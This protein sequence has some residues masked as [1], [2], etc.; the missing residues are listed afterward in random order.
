MCGISGFID[1][2]NISGLDCIKAMTDVLHHRGPDDSGLF[3]KQYEG[4]HVGLGHR[5]LSILD[6]SSHGHQP[7]DHRHL[8]I[9]YNGEVYNFKEIRTEL[10][11]QGYV[12]DSGSDTE[13]ILKAYHCW[14]IEMVHRLNGMFALAIFDAEKKELVLLRDRAGV[15]P[16]YWYYHD[17]LFLF[18]SELKSF[19]QHPAFK[20]ELCLDGLALFLQYGYIPQPHSIFKHTQKLKAGNSL[21]INLD[22]RSFE[23]KKY[24]DV[25]DFY[26]KPK[27]K[28]S[29]EEALRETERLLTSACEY[30]MVADVPVGVFL[31]G[32]Y[33]SS[34]VTALL[35]S[36][37]SEKLKTFAIGFHEEAYNEAHHARRVAEHLGTD[38]TEYYCTHQDALDILP[39]LPEIWDEP[40]GDAST[41]PTVLVSELARKQV[42]VSLSADGGDE[43][44]GGYDKYI[45]AK[46]MESIFGR[47]P[48]RNQFGRFL[49]SIKPGSIP[50]LSRDPIFSRRYAKVASSL[51]AKHSTEMLGII[52]SAFFRAEVEELIAKPIVHLA[53]DFESYEGLDEFNDL[54]N[55]LMAVDYKT[56]QLDDILVKVDRAT[57]SCSLE[58]RE[59][60]LDYRII[61]Y[62]ARLESS[63]KIRGDER[64]YLLKK[65]THQYLPKEMMDRP[66][67]GFGV[68]IL[69]WFRAELR[70]Y[71]LSYLSESRLA[72]AGIFNVNKVIEV[73]DEYLNGKNDD[74]SKI[75]F[76]LVF[77]MWREKWM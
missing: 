72:E 11:R 68:P 34:A 36:H 69:D 8:T 30:R 16:L 33:D 25:L 26:R 58:G 6:L 41:I 54:Y 61:E 65:I 29:E 4:A 3:Y 49:S 19:H 45:Y 10:E 14:G 76:L 44:F 55:S 63:L 73:R 77:E 7:M 75:W 50:F 59:P 51:E 1:W 20:K 43:I 47:V 17:G 66:K 13:V 21:T 52:G 40:F 60:L 9:V 42:T 12:F 38:H 74:I 32:G 18:A 39:R 2:K 67:M 22:Q 53:T 27:L 37:R 48:F 46:K 57:M 62:V 56:Y 31:S 70:D 23:E 24:W 5:R 35:Q 64:K 15:K 28:V 71:L